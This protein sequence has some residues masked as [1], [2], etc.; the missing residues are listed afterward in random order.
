MGNGNSNPS[1]SAE[2][3]SKLSEGEKNALSLFGN[4]DHFSTTRMLNYNKARFNLQSNCLVDDKL[5]TRKHYSGYSQFDY[6][7]SLVQINFQNSVP[8]NDDVLKNIQKNLILLSDPG[9]SLWWCMNTEMF[10]NEFQNALIKNENGKLNL[11]SILLFYVYKIDYPLKNSPHAMVLLFNSKRNTFEYF[12]SNNYIKERGDFGK[13]FTSKHSLEAMKNFLD[14]PENKSRFQVANDILFPNND[15]SKFPAVDHVNV[16]SF[17]NNFKLN[18]MHYFIFQSGGQCMYWG[19]IFV[20]ARFIL[21]NL[22]DSPKNIL[23]KLGE[24]RPDLVE[25]L[26]ELG[27]SDTYY[28]SKIDWININLLIYC[29]KIVK[30]ESRTL[31][32]AE[33]HVD[34]QCMLQNNDCQNFEENAKTTM[35]SDLI[36]A[37]KTELEQLFFT[38]KREQHFLKSTTETSKTKTET[39]IHNCWKYWKHWSSSALQEKILWCQIAMIHNS[40]LL[41]KEKDFWLEKIALF[42]SGRNP[43]S[44]IYQKREKRLYDVEIQHPI[45]STTIDNNN[46]PNF[47]PITHL[48]LPY[49]SYI[50]PFEQLDDVEKYIYKTCSDPNPT[51]QL[52]MILTDWVMK[53]P[54]DHLQ[55]NFI[56]NKNTDHLTKQMLKQYEL[57]K[58]NY[59]NTRQEIIGRKVVYYKYM[60]ENSQVEV[61]LLKE[62]I[63]VLTALYIEKKLDL[64]YHHLDSNFISPD[65]FT[66]EILY[67]CEYIVDRN[68]HQPTIYEYALRSM[69][70]VMHSLNTTLSKYSNIVIRDTQFQK[71]IN[72]IYVILDDT[73][74]IPLMREYFIDH[75]KKVTTTEIT[76][77]LITSL[78]KVLLFHC[79][80]RFDSIETRIRDA[81]LKQYRTRITPDPL[82][83]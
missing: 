79:T 76:T 50:H 15:I 59:Y 12:D 69:P 8:P 31:R 32:N 30:F 49:E 64:R 1:S 13:S 67:E 20:Y 56:L 46:I 43:Q 37:S 80:N 54:K 18:D 3:L 35:F 74:F 28:F 48:L 24:S 42:L 6:C 71:I 9:S 75:H 27:I 23:I 53:L 83:F 33:E 40:Y 78:R 5:K 82:L 36:N 7:P 22:E 45:Y 60:H 19:E 38:D 21:C 68:Q 73:F 63:Q 11:K 66:E 2:I 61:K 72:Q 65:K 29:Y 58:N 57:L 55:Q 62:K 39:L 81:A 77:A 14:R 44:L 70:D 25:W 4:Y 17:E 34:N 47:I 10:F 51:D 52:M 41:Y 26:E 16:D